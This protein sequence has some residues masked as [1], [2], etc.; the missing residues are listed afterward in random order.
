M[1]PNTK[2]KIKIVAKSPKELPFSIERNV[3]LATLKK[4]NPYQDVFSAM[5]DG[6]SFLIGTDDDTVKSVKYQAAKFAQENNVKFSI[7]ITS[8]GHRCW[9]FKK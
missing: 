2:A 7:R 9:K 8:D 5:K 6:D 1:K 3:P 4:P